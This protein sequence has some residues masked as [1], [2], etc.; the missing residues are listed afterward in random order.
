MRCR[1]ER[2]GAQYLQLFF[3]FSNIL[4]CEEHISDRRLLATE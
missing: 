1:H 4:N 3:S 2:R